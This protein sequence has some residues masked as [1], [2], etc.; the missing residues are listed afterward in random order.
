[1]PPG[2]LTAFADHGDVARTIDTGLDEADA[3]IRQLADL[4]ISLTEVTAEL[5]H[6]GVQKFADSYTDLL[7]TIEKRRTELVS[8]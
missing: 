5:E 8:A 2:T 1:M 7:A 4:G 6:E 3:A